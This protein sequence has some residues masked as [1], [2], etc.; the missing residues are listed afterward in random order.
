MIMKKTILLI[1][2]ILVSWSLSAQAETAK[3]SEPAKKQLIA[4]MKIVAK[5]RGD[6]WW[7]GKIDAVKGEFIEVTFADNTKAIKK[8]N[9]VVPHPDVLYPYNQPPC[10]KAGDIVVSVW[11]GNS[12]WKAKIDKVTGD[13]AEV[14]YVDGEKGIHKFNEMV[15]HP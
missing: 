10:F 9:E 7:V 8:A 1:T 15:R 14:T 2:L 5:W 11:R 13:I 4:G 3:C 12:W 6:N